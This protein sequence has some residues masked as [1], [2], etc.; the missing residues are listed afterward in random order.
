VYINE[1]LNGLLYAVE[2]FKPSLL[3]GH[4]LMEKGERSLVATLASEVL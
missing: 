1:T 4:V 2:K 3:V